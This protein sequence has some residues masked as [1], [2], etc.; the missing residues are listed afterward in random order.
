MRA[1]AVALIVSMPV[2]VVGLFFG[3]QANAAPLPACQY[4]DGQPCMWTDP[5]TGR[6]FYVDSEGY[7]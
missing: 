3:D 6:Q 1:A 2:V 4:E 5:D 7:R